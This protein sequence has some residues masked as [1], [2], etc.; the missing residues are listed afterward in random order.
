MSHVLLAA[1][2]Y[3]NLLHTAVIF[4]YCKVNATRVKELHLSP[5]SS[6]H[7]TCTILSQN[8]VFTSEAGVRFALKGKKRVYLFHSSS[9][10]PH[11]WLLLFSLVK[12]NHSRWRAACWHLSSLFYLLLFVPFKWN[13]YMKML[14]VFLPFYAIFLCH[15]SA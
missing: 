6:I 5:T 4:L 2:Y 7:R 11:C 9:H 1:A 12:L 15:V 13:V 10:Y 8:R 3:R 14:N